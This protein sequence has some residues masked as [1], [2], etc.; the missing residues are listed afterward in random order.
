MPD[1][2]NTIII[3]AGEILAEMSRKLNT[4]FTA[5]FFFKVLLVL[6]L[7]DSLHEPAVKLSF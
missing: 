5:L 1:H 4:F 3:G 6:Q 7:L 2:V